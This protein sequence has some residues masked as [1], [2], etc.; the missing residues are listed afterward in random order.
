MIGQGFDFL[1]VIDFI[2]DTG[3]E[4]YLIT[5]RLWFGFFCGLDFIEKFACVQKSSAGKTSKPSHIG[6]S[7]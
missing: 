5:N 7:Q 1:H 2:K 6:F 4:T 3:E